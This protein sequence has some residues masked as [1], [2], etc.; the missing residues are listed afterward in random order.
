MEAGKVELS[1]LYTAIAGLFAVIT[2][3]LATF[4]GSIQAIADT[5][6]KRIANT[7]LFKRFMRYIKVA[8]LVGFVM[9]LSSIPYIVLAP[10]AAGSPF[11]RVL[12]AIWCGTCVYG[13]A[14][15][16]RVAG[17]LFFIFEHQPPED[18]GAT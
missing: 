2:G 5:R 14:L 3:F 9:A 1:N 17:L 13:F 16:V 10:T 18:E 7:I 6:L 15:F 4:Y 12:V 11:A 8:T